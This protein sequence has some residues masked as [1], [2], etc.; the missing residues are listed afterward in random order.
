[1]C[2]TAVVQTLTSTLSPKTDQSFLIV[3]KCIL[4]SRRA[5]A[6]RYVTGESLSKS[7]QVRVPTFVQKKKLGPVPKLLCFLHLTMQFRNI[8]HR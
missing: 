2:I 4:Q 7:H 3:W 8:A 5:L 6:S 1:M